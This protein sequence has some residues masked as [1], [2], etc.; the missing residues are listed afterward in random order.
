MKAV[1]L[2]RNPLDV[3]ASYA[4]HNNCTIDQAIRMMNKKNGYLARQ[5][6]GFN[7]NNQLPQLMYSWSGHAESWHNQDRMEVHTVRYEDMKHKGLETFYQV[8]T[9]LGLEVT[10]EEVAEAIELTKFE[11]LKKAEEEKGFQEKN[12][13]SPSFFRK[14]R[15]GGYKE[16]LTEGQIAL[17]CEAHGETMQRFGYELP[18]DAETI[19]RLAD[20]E[21]ARLEAER[22]RLEAKVSDTSKMSDT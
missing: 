2:I 17:I 21:R 15:T 1:Y 11:K 16:E 22:T 7:I 13:S 4:N 6:N 18:M 12:I 9:G 10:E 5:K 19:Q 20:E 14:G 8:I 3:V